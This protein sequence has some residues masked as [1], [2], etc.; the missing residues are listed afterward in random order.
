MWDD[1]V[2][3]RPLPDASAGKEKE[4]KENDSMLMTSVLHDR[5]HCYNY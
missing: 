1:S 4:E 2:V 5:Q 3:I